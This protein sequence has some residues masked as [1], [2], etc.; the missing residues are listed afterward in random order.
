MMSGTIAAS[1]TRSAIAPRGFLELMQTSLDAVP[2]S[3]G[4]ARRD[5]RLA[6]RKASSPRRRLALG[7]GARTVGEDPAESM[8]PGSAIAP[9]RKAPG[10]PGAFRV[11][12]PAQTGLNR[13][14]NIVEAGVP[15][16]LQLR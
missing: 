12:L 9:K 7:G 13:T 5:V 3:R 14:R 15:A 11:A 6:R 2:T 4:P 8:E 10:T 1:A 16:G